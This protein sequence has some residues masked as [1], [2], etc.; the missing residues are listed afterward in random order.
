VIVATVGTI[1][2]DGT[3]LAMTDYPHAAGSAS[4]LLG[5]I[6]F[7]LGAATAPLAGLAGRQTALPMALLIA[8]LGAGALAAVLF[9]RSALTLYRA[10]PAR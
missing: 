8:L 9:A 6:Q 1:V 2:P 4:A 3:A 10:R 5:A 7:L